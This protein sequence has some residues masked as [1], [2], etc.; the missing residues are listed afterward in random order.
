M[1]KKNYEYQVLETELEDDDSCTLHTGIVY[2]TNDRSLAH[3]DCQLRNDLA[4]LHMTKKLYTLKRVEK[5]K[6]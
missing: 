5:E 6:E 2:T 3:N 1:E 4:V